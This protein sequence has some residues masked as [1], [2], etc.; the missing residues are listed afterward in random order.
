MCYLESDLAPD[1]ANEKV[2]QHLKQIGKDNSI[3]FN[4]IYCKK[5]CFKRTLSLTSRDRRACGDLGDFTVMTSRVHDAVHIQGFWKSDVIQKCLGYGDRVYEKIEC[6]VVHNVQYS[7][8][9]PMK[10]S[11][12]VAS[13]GDLHWDWDWCV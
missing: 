8:D 2:L 7:D 10:S 5:S 11:V 3:A 9:V 13:E 4:R 12:P 6:L 1:E